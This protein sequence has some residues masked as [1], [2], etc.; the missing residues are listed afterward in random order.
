MNLLAIAKI[1]GK[2]LKAAG[3]LTGVLGTKA[4]GQPVKAR[5]SRMAASVAALLVALLSWGGIPEPV[6]VALSDV[7]V[8]LALPTERA[9]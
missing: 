7:A 2:A 5:K 6:A 8:E 3:A 4:S 9:P 1:A